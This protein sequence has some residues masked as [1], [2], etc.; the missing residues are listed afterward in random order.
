[1]S[2]NA[3]NSLVVGSTEVGVLVPASRCSPS[4]WRVMKLS[5]SEPSMRCRLRSASAMVNSGFT[6]KC[7]AAW[8]RGARSMSATLPWAECSES[9]MFTATVVAPVPPLAFTMLNTLPRRPLWPCLRCAAVRRTNAS[10]R[11]VVVVGR[12]MYS[13]APARMAFTIT[14]G[15]DML[16]MAKTAAL[17]TSAR[18]V[19]MARIA[20]VALSWGMSTSNTSGLTPWMRRNSGSVAATGNAGQLCTVRATLVPSTSTCSTERCSSSVASITTANSAIRPL[21]SSLGKSCLLRRSAGGCLRA[22]D[23]ANRNRRR[24]AAGARAAS[25]AAAT[26]AGDQVGRDIS[27]ALIHPIHKNFHEPD[28]RH[29][30][31][32]A[33]NGGL[34][35]IP[36][37]SRDQRLAGIT[38]QAGVTVGAGRRLIAEHKSL[39]CRVALVPAVGRRPGRTDQIGDSPI[40]LVGVVAVLGLQA[41]SALAGKIRQDRGIHLAAGVIQAMGDDAAIGAGAGA[42]VQRGILAGY[43]GI[44]G[45]HGPQYDRLPHLA[46]GKAGELARAAGGEQVLAIV[47]GIDDGGIR[48]DHGVGNVER[49]QAVA[50]ARLGAGFRRGPRGYAHRAP[51]DGP[52]KERANARRPGAR[53]VYGYPPA[54][55]VGA[56]PCRG[57]GGRAGRGRAES[58]VRR[59]E[60]LAQ[61]LVLHRH[62]HRRVLR[63][64]G[65]RLRGVLE[66]V[67]SRQRSRVRRVLGA[68]ASGVQ[69]SQIN[70]QGGKGEQH[71]DEHRHQGQRHSLFPPAGET[72]YHLPPPGLLPSN[73]FLSSQG[74]GYC[75]NGGATRS[76]DTFLAV[77]STMSSELLLSRLRLRNRLPS[78]GMSPR[79]GI[80]LIWVVTR[81]SIKPAMTKLCPS[82]IWNSV[83]ALRVLSAGTV[84]PEMVSALAK[85]S[86]LTSGATLR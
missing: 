79:P 50:A 70:S 65:L 15:C 48:R 78:T 40:G 14:C 17:L 43:A 52:G 76:G 53:D 82:C 66:S 83:A 33:A 16:P 45:P 5:S 46:L 85:S 27:R 19:S 21:P 12:S 32:A 30:L 64:G 72:A 73:L 61:N 84:K 8:P 22:L 23:Q 63:R 67:G 58:E 28:Q 37:R 1:M 74:L 77:T 59:R 41:V 20:A 18:S 38:P 86:A 51:A 81:L 9:A 34:A 49:L 47:A 26:A 24:T 54:G 3:A 71:H 13:R 69:H 11:A 6:F 42:E 4:G 62:C 25:A 36:H 55:G 7:R 56:N 10:S 68:S 75:G 2:N 39:R 29:R 80:L 44:L 31:L 57:A 35:V 60:R